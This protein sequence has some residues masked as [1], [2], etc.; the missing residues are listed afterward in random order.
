MELRLLGGVQSNRPTQE[1]TNLVVIQRHQN[2]DWATL[3]VD[4][5]YAGQDEREQSKALKGLWE[6]DCKLIW[7][8]LLVGSGVQPQIFFLPPK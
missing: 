1:V 2:S 8:A 5:F 4:P 7:V 6:S 3:R